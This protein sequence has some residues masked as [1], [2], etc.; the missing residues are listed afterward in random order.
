LRP[1]LVRSGPRSRHPTL[2]LQRG[3]FSGRER[4]YGEMH[5]GGRR[6]FRRGV[7]R[8]LELCA[9]DR[10]GSFTIRPFDA[11]EQTGKT[12]VR[13]YRHPGESCLNRGCVERKEQAAAHLANL[14]AIVNPREKKNARIQNDK[15]PSIRGEEKE[16]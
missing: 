7:R 6:E 3:V 4:A 10:N 12:Y 15:I 13:A 16:E 5:D 1:I 2:L 14:V 8:K 11:Q 9:I